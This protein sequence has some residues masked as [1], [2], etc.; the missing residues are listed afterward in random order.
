MASQ[1]SQRRRSAKAGSKNHSVA[2][3][4][5]PPGPRGTP[6]SRCRDNDISISQGTSRPT[7]TPH[8]LSTSF[9]SSF[10]NQ[11][12]SFFDMGTLS[13]YPWDLP[14]SGQQ[15]DWWD[16][17]N[18]PTLSALESALGS[19]PCVALSRSEE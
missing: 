9:L 6:S 7:R 5:G 4:G 13:P 2:W 15:Y 8:P 3:W 11:E 19:H 18:C 14:L 12:G 10:L 1:T 16:S 17:R